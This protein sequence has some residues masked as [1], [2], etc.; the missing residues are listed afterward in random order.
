MNRNLA[1]WLL[2]FNVFFP[3]SSTVVIFHFVI[4]FRSSHWRCSVRK[5]ILKTV[6][7]AKFLRTPYLQNTSA[8]A[9]LFLLI[10]LSLIRD[11]TNPKNFAGHKIECS[12]ICY[13]Y[14]VATLW[15]LSRWLIRHCV[16]HKTYSTHLCFNYECNKHM[17]N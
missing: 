16:P 11:S 1:Y 14:A 5:G 8:T 3:G 7:F 13:H 9:R 6:N 12:L 4:L 15:V 10:Q 17:K 2:L